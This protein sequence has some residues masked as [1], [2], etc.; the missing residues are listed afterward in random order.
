MLASI[1][2]M[3]QC[4][5]ITAVS[6]AVCEQCCM[7]QPAHLV[8]AK[9]EKLHVPVVIPCQPHSPGSCMRHAITDCAV[10]SCCARATVAGPILL[11]T[12][13]PALCAHCWQHCRSAHD[14][15]ANQ[16]TLFVRRSN[17]FT[18]PLSYPASTQ[19]SSSLKE[20]PKATH[21]Q[22]LQPH[23]N[24][25]SSSSAAHCSL[26]RYTNPTA[27]ACCSKRM[28]R[29]PGGLSFLGQHR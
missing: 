20:F 22:S 26:N 10:Q 5:Y 18:S 11:G 4:Q 14:A 3:W 27:L 1:T 24:S 8:C 21:Q 25:C 2:C 15:R 12:L 28:A 7:C 17:S 16:H 23:T 6:T 13:L 29:G 19:R 9:V